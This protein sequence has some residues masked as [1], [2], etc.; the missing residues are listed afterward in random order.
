MATTQ[1]REGLTIPIAQAARIAGT[2]WETMREA[3][4]IGQVP[5]VVIG[6]K[7]RVL[8]EPFLEMLGERPEHGDSVS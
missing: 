6:R 8:R 2:G 3:V 4:R 5:S 1:E 7:P